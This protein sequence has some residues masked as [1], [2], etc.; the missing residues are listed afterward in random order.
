MATRH[1]RLPVLAAAAVVLGTGVPLPAGAACPAPG[2]EAPATALRAG[3]PATVTGTSFFEGCNDTPEPGG[4]FHRPEPVIEPPRRDVAL[5][6]TQ[7]GRSWT[8]QRADAAG[9]EEQYRVRWDFEV[10]A[11]VKPG[12]ATL[13]VEDG[14]PLPVTI[15]R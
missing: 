3:S 13:T 2:L 15:R 11:D 8:L 5:V 12:R 4:C 1:L 7:G 9:P 10:P 6:L 14:L